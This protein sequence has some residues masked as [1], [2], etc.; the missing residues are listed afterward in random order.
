MAESLPRIYP[1]IMCG[2]A[3]TRLWPV[4]TSRTPKQFRHL[5]S[6][7][8]IFQD[9]ILRVQPGALA[10]AHD[11]PL[12]VSNIAYRDQ[13]ESQLQELGIEPLAMLL[14]PVGRNTSAVA[15]VASAFIHKID[16]DGLV[17]LLPSDHFVGRPD[18]FCAAVNDAAAVSETGRIVTF[19]IAPDRPETGFG[20]IRS[21]APLAPSIATVAAFREKP[22]LPTAQAYLSD[23]A[24]SWNAGIFLFPASLML[25]EI[26]RLAPG[27]HAPA[28]ASLEAAKVAGAAISLDTE[29]FEQ[30]DAISIDYAVMEKTD[31]AAVYAPLACG[32]SDVG[33][34]PMIGALE[35]QRTRVD[36]ILIDV[37]DCTIHAHDETLIA[38]IGIR[39]LVIVSVEGAMLV[40]PKSR[41]QDVGKIVATLKARGDVD[42]V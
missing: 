3:G 11:H 8:S 2:G 7:R 5:L 4:S 22:D 23:P 27:T 15:A 24:Y 16:P 20:Y 14:E 28:L 30:V 37:E 19:G 26:A 31:K 33:T 35:P 9:T 41:A 6:D 32:W 25:A 12:I 13:I 36:P 42:R 18:A 17:L 1:V 40:M 10:G 39:D 34:W 21:G 29:Q 38:A